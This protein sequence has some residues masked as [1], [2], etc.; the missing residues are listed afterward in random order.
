[1]SQ[2][3]SAGRLAEQNAR[4]KVR[5]EKLQRLLDMASET[6]LPSVA[7]PEEGAGSGYCHPPEGVA[8][9]PLARR[10]E[11]RDAARYFAG[12][13]DRFRL[14]PFPGYANASAADGADECIGLNL[15]GAD[16]S[17]WRNVLRELQTKI[18]KGGNYTYVVVTGSSDFTY[19][20]QRG[21]TFEYISYLDRLNDAKWRA[22]FELNMELIKRKYGLNEFVS[23][24]EARYRV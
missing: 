9:E 5:I 8:A 22:Y 20:I 2:A 17:V 1:M 24:G 16:E 19:F 14:I 13:D 6:I 3:K 15:L 21:I 11:A 12:N 4:L 10:P 7:S 23:I 18:A